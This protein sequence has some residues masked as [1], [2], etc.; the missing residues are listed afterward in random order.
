M[1][2]PC[3]CALPE[4]LHS[5]REAVGEG[6]T[7][8]PYLAALATLAL[9]ARAADPTLWYV[10]RAAAVS[11]YV[12]L[13]LTVDLGMLRSVARELSGR[14]SWL[15]DELHQFISLLAAAFVALHLLALLFDPFISFS[16]LNLLLPLGQPYRPVPVDLGV[17]ALYALGVVLVSSWLR[18]RMSQR[19]WR[20]LHNASF[21]V[22]FLATLHGLLAG[23]DAGQPWMHA[24]YVGAAA[25]V[26]FL[27]VARIFAQPSER[28]QD[29]PVTPR[30]VD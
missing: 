10:T 9:V 11:A 18:R 23:S 6:E 2:P 17:L 26:L 4:R 27:V 16:P 25:S 19:T 5:I 13:L 30:R 15:L 8:M 12:L 21:A 1:T 24:L 22:F 28:A 20:T 3:R 14:V 7:N 29:T